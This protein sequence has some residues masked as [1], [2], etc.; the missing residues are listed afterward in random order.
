MSQATRQAPAV[1]T[2]NPSDDD[3][4]NLL[5]TYLE[6]HVQPLWTAYDTLIGELKSLHLVILANL[7]N[8]A[9]EKLRILRFDVNC[10][11]EGLQDHTTFI[12]GVDARFDIIGA[13]LET[14]EQAVLVGR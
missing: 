8:V 7:S 10:V 1:A 9:A 14:R 3:D 4:E 11:W 5:G 6:S 2:S 12:E 13:C